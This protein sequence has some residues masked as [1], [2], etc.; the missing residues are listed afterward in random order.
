MKKKLNEKTT[1]LF[2]I[3][4]IMLAVWLGSAAYSVWQE[5]QQLCTNLQQA[6]TL[7]TKRQQFASEHADYDSYKRQQSAR[8][9]QLQAQ[10]GEQLQLNNVM[11]RMQKQA[12]TQ[13]VEIIALHA[14]Q[15]Q[16]R[17]GEQLTLQQLKIV[18]TGDFFALLRWLRQAEHVG[19]RVKQLRLIQG[20]QNKANLTMELNAELHI[21]N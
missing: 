2:S 15:G 21:T 6:Q 12:R 16:R 14:G 18:A 1:L 13:Q 10:A 9:T 5:R 3:L 17:Q 11:Q 4:I 19:C 20:P 7:L 8:L